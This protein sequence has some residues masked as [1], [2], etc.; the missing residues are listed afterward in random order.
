MSL[1]Q[2]NAVP[3]QNIHAPLA[4]AP[5]PPQLPG[6]PAPEIPPQP[7][8]PLLEVAPQLQVPNNAAAINQVPQ[9]LAYQP[10][11]EAHI[12]AI[13]LGRMNV[14]CPKCGALHWKCECLS[15]SP[16]NHPWFG[17]CC[18]NGKVE[19]PIITSPPLELQKLFDGC[20]PHAAEFKKNIRAYNAAFAMASLG[21]K[22]DE[23]VTWTSG[24]YVFKIK[25]TL[26][27][28]AGSLLPADGTHPVYAQLY[29]YEPETA[30][31]RRMERN[32]A[33]NN[34]C[35]LNRQVIQSLKLRMWFILKFCF[36]EIVSLIYPLCL[37]QMLI[38]TSNGE[39]MCTYIDC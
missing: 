34:N 36:D 12:A 19:L 32:A 39:I 18:L 27:H 23:A 15:K 3:P 17:T 1:S 5:L 22:M 35:G 37:K 29:F 21:V 38:F 26:F 28:N 14:V 7:Q 13:D 24:P 25:G 33:V 8:L 4:P 9:G 16:A 20:D 11:V 2:K 6:P 31:N 10:V 30:L